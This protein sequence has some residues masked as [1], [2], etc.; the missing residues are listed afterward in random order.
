MREEASD[1]KCGNDGF[2]ALG[3]V[4]DVYMAPA[5][6]AGIGGQG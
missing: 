6:G 3:D 4:C 5:H 1:E 2:Y